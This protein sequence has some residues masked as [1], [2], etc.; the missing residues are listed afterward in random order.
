MGW[1]LVMIDETRAAYGVKLG[2][3]RQKTEGHPAAVTGC[4]DAQGAG[5]PPAQNR[6]PNRV[7]RA[8]GHPRRTAPEQNPQREDARIA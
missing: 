8:A 4:A 3:G 1:T 6:R 2:D 7:R 5:P